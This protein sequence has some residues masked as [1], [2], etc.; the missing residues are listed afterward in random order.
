MRFDEPNTENPATLLKHNSVLCT[1][2]CVWDV[3]TSQMPTGILPV[4]KNT[5]SNFKLKIH[6]TT[7]IINMCLILKLTENSG[8]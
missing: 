8:N 7:F 1:H 3:R 5:C 6:S 2:C 4:S